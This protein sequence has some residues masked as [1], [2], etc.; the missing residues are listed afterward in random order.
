LANSRTTSLHERLPVELRKQVECDLVEQ[1]PGRSTYAEVYEHYQLDV[2]GVSLKALERYGGYLRSL[3][4]NEWIRQ[5]GNELL[6]DTDLR[7]NI[8]GM[9]RARM[10]EALASADETRLGDLLKAALTEKSLR[11][12]VIRTEEWEAKKKQMAAEL[13]RIA[14]KAE[15]KGHGLS[16]EVLDE[17]RSKVLGI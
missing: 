6:A 14:R 4:R 15:H 7:P 3:K 17:I 11:E 8:E 1:P 10:Y 2:H 5:V 9:I 16:A 13:E 12:S